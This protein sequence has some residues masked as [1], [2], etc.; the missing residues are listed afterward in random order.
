MGTTTATSSGHRSA[1][2]PAGEAAGTSHLRGKRA[3]VVLFSYYPTDPRPRRAA[4]ALVREGMAVDLVC[5][6]ETSRDPAR[7][8]VNGVDVLR[9]PLRRR[10]GNTLAYLWQYLAFLVASL[11]VLAGRSVTR[12][13]SLVH[14]HNMPDVLVLSALV[15]K[16]LGAKVL[17]DLHDPMPELMMTI[18]GLAPDSQKV[19]LLRRL[20]R[21]SIGFADRVITVNLACTR[22]FVGRSC[23]AEKMRVV[24]NSP[25]EEIFRFRP[26]APPSL[27]TPEAGKPFVIMY[28][29]SLVERNGLDLAVDALARL[30]AT[31]PGVRLQIFGAS[32]PYLE[33]T[34]ESVQAKGLVG[35]V[36]YLGPRRIEDIAAAIEGCDVGIIPN[37][38][39]LFTEL[40]TPTRIFEYLAMGKPVVA[41]RA[42]GILDYFGAD[43]L[44]YFD[45]GDPAS[46]AAAVERVYTHP[47][48]TFD[49]VRRGQAVYQTHAWGEE[50]KTFL[51]LA[52]EL[53]D[54][55]RTAA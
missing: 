26:A 10:R 19:R 15:P 47:R 53:L 25:D 27:S 34:L 30:R 11:V 8:T 28:H 49:V 24:M 46:L 12:R 5:L 16:L 4:E 1:S 39:S 6:R 35:A 48:E 51:R 17:L 52:A 7:E 36:D 13:Y 9:I 42:A 54:P 31:V 22:L 18:F 50:R 55:S 2:R 38:R 23:P 3:A 44:V 41:P 20:E 45:L 32:T 37:R 33:R 29:G 14:V 43:S 21:A 40:N